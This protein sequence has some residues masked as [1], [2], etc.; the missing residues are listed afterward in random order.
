MAA[1]AIPS[2]D[3]ESIRFA[4]EATAAQS[5]RQDA[6]M[7]DLI[8]A[9]QARPKPEVSRVK[10]NLMARSLL[11]TQGMA[12]KIWAA[13]A[14][15]AELL[16]VTEPIEIYQ[17]AGAENAAIHLVESPVFLEIRGR[18]VSLL[19]DQGTIS[20]FGHELGHYLAHGQGSPNAEL[21]P[22]AS[23]ALSHSGTP[24]H[25]QERASRFAMAREITADRF[26]LLA[27]Q[28]LEAALRVEM[29]LT[30]G[31]ATDELQWDTKAYLAQSKALIE[32]TLAAGESARGSSHPEHGV[33]AWAVWL[34]SETALYKELTGQGPGTREMAD[35]DALIAQALGA[36]P[37][38]GITDGALAL[39]PIPE[40]H[41]C[42]LASAVLV[43]LADDEMAEEE[44]LA[45]E[46]IFA[47]LVPDWQR[48]LNW[49]NAME[50][51]YDT[52]VVVI[53][54]GASVQRSVFQVL[55]HVM[56][57]DAKVLQSEIEMICSIGD[58][59]QCGTLF[60]ALLTPVLQAMGQ[61]VPDLD[62]VERV[63]AMPARADEA[64][65]ALEIFLRGILR[66]RG[67]QLSLRRI[68]RLL[69]DRE[70]NEKSREVLHRWLSE[71]GLVLELAEGDVLEE[72]ELDRPL[73][74]T[75]SPEALAKLDAET[76][77]ELPDANQP[78][79]ERLTRAL[80]RLREGLVSGD[81]RS[82]AIRLRRVRT[83][84][85]VDLYTLEGL[86]VGHAE[87]VLTLAQAG[88]TARL[89]DGKEVGVHEGAAA[90]SVELVALQRQDAL[91][92]E[93]T[94]ARD[95][96]LGAPF[97]TGVFHG[98][99]VR[100]PLILHPV[101]LER[102]QG[103]GFALES[104]DDEPPVANQALI[105]LLF[106][107]KNVSFPEDLSEELDRAAAEGVEAIR[108]LIG[109]HGII[110]RPESSAGLQRFKPR[111]ED[112][113]TWPNSRVV[114]EQVAVVG[115]FPQSSSDMIQD[116]D[117]LLAAVADPTVDL[118]ERLGT[119]GPLLPADLRET[120]GILSE[121]TPSTAPLIPV[122]QADPTQLGVLH[123]ARR[124]RAL[125]V[126]GPPGTGKSQ[127]IV[128]LVADA[129]AQ[130]QSVAVVCEK[131]AALDVVAQRLEQLGMR[132]LLAVV[133]DVHEDRR[134][135]YN[136]VQGRLGD[137]L[138]RDHDPDRSTQIATDL[139]SVTESLKGRRDAL[140]QVL[141]DGRPSLGQLHLLASSFETP[142]LDKLDPG[143]LNTPHR[144]VRR[145]SELVGRE[146]LHL[147][148]HSKQSLWRA[149]VGSVRPSLQ[150]HSPEQ[151]AEIEDTLAAARESA[152]AVDALRQDPPLNEDLLH[153]LRAKLQGALDSADSRT[154]RMAE[155]AFS[156]WIQAGEDGGLDL[157]VQ[158]MEAAWLQTDGTAP[159]WTEIVPE[160][161]TFEGSPQLQDAL[162]L[163]TDKGS[164]FLRFFSW[165]WWQARGVIK[166]ALAA[167][168]PAAA[169]AP[170][171]PVLL[172]R[173]AQ[174]QDGAAAWKALDAVLGALQLSPVLPD[175]GHAHKTV[176]TLLST[177][178]AT[179]ELVSAQA[180]LSEVQAWPGQDL[181][182]W[183]NTLRERL[184]LL[185]ALDAHA[186]T[187]APAQA[188]FPWLEAAPSG[189]L[190]EALHEAWAIDAPRV[191]LS[192]RN[193]ATASTLHSSARDLA[194]RLA[195]RESDPHSAI[196]W[197]ESIEHGWAL[198][199]LR[200]LERRHPGVRTLDR[201]TPFGELPE[202]EAQLS[203]LI[204]R[205]AALHA[206]MILAQ[207]DR[208]PLLMEGRPDKGARRTPLQKAREQMLREATKKRYVLSLRGFVRQFSGGGLMDLL[209]V[210]LVSPETMAVLFPGKPIF[211]V[212]VMDEASQCTVEKGFPALIRGH[213]AV[214]AGD[215]K[216]MPPS[217]F[218]ALR[219]PGEDE[220]IGTAET[221]EAD[222][223]TAE[224][225]LVLARERCAHEGLRW[226][227]RCAH[228]ELIAFSNHAM[229]GGELFTIPSTRTRNAPAALRWVSVPD[230]AYDKGVNPREADVIVDEIAV[231]L[232]Q[233]PVPSIGVVTFNVQQRQVILDA[234]DLR[235]ERDA[236]FGEAWAVAST[237]ET[238]DQRP[239]VKNLE[240]VQGDE[241]DIILFSM[242][243]APV[244]R[245]SGP[246]KGQPY[247]PSRFGPLGQAGGERRL[248]VAVSRAKQGCVVV[249]SFEP[250]ML[251]VAHTKNE[252]PKLLKAFLEF[253][254]D[255]THGRRVQA[256]K[257]LQRVR[258]G[259]LGAVA[260]TRVERLGVPS[261]GAQI[262]MALAPH[263]VEVD[264][265]VGSSG[266]QVPLALRN[267]DHYTLAVLTEEG[268][269]SG[270]VD[271]R[272]VHHPGVLRARGWAVE[273]VN[274]RDWHRDS[275]AILERLLA[276]HRDV[277]ERAAQSLREAALLRQEAALRL[278]EA[279]RPE[280]APVPPELPA[281]EPP[282]GPPESVPE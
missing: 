229:Y 167:Q 146:A 139:A 165:A 210:W 116:Y 124:A 129:L 114:V 190:C 248:N 150:D 64:E 215:E 175:S 95:L 254:W 31:L 120:L 53:R 168:W 88:Q 44:A 59:L 187:F 242:G 219:A 172:T 55:V 231:L 266:F 209:P 122:V 143:L 194:Q 47:H 244:P 273:R 78:A 76:P 279:E 160:R 193:L 157:L 3:I 270:D 136:Q 60:R 240:S 211:D 32:M 42:A 126:D 250:Q 15:A 63:I 274:A 228:E 109:S 128:N 92:N 29:V 8:V 223:L 12:P 237:H 45:I 189:T 154:G 221:V 199:A 267:G 178:A 89:V 232:Q 197:S 11:L 115:F 79:R 133:H 177:Y 14:Q 91:K 66:R 238:L 174:R 102:S 112:F 239:F 28:D 196:L 16:G 161:A 107:K 263:G 243:H 30:T 46:K 25:A 72:I 182:A 171:N 262:A 140:A 105:R 61:E 203:A 259:G 19:D 234:V 208:V 170:F 93:Q 277:V 70:G 23:L 56:A 10:R 106:S 132:H 272:H 50:A 227:Y 217:S 185:D 222:A 48:Y 67:G 281:S 169:E 83:G 113:A 265:D 147:A 162:T 80:S 85:S 260:K 186:Q 145:L 246:L 130:G 111:D 40:V 264:L 191:V 20:V 176:Q 181:E 57:A 121:Q 6:W 2:L 75:L 276:R 73:D 17:A 224:S 135:L 142:A 200:A 282:E 258:H 37:S 144:S 108:A 141:S 218:F 137:S 24:E 204:T 253:A 247:V 125:V 241:R 58:A 213:R 202:T 249:C 117:D 18:L 235:C 90:L 183:D 252:G 103:R 156:A 233:Q 269:G 96:Y 251:S 245:R 100:A 74:L 49:D 151:L 77:P 97:L 257:T 261:L 271:E 82:P 214:I 212:V 152:K 68:Y 43:A 104:R 195:D 1:Q 205:R 71:L 123:T 33:R 255:L 13:A 21:G 94:G 230:G 22:V 35:I 98:Y 27:C 275:G 206:E 39:D 9:A 268:H 99:L 7:R 163:S 110:A 118:A 158:R 220:E 54:G 86:S 149:P 188:C 256:D 87:R 280:P 198:S 225:L 180:S 5:M 155:Q 34:F 153:T 164:S 127:V 51:F 65:A 236:A 131:R 69:G 148:L 52:G 138:L 226:H 159:E 184:A 119:A 36:A 179:R 38:E 26:G 166:R 4:G 101:K 216:Q 201:P 81:G 192:D 84:R 41:E 207:R 62:A 278:E 173:I 134:G